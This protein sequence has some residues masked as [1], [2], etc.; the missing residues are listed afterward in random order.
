MCS[1]PEAATNNVFEEE[2]DI[3]ISGAQTL[4]GGITG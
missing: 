4:R 3:R 1:G 2:N